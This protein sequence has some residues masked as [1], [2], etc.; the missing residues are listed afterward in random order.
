M[1]STEKIET[2]DFILKHLY[3][4][5]DLLLLWQNHV[6]TTTTMFTLVKVFLEFKK[7]KSCLFTAT[8]VHQ[9]ARGGRGVIRGG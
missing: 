6:F 7:I 1:D 5:T 2:V 4:H 8:E 9:V 3:N